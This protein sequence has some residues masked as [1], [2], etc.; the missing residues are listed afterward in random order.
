MCLSE[1]SWKQIFI[2]AIIFGL[3]LKAS[4]ALNINSQER[5]SKAIL[6]HHARSRLWFYFRQLTNKALALGLQ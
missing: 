3:K 6:T 5:E 4:S 2:I 1:I